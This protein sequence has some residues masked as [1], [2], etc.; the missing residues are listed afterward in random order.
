MELKVAQ[1]FKIDYEINRRFHLRER[2]GK[3]R[4]CGQFDTTP[5]FEDDGG[6]ICNQCWPKF[7]SEHVIK[8]TCEHCGTAVGWIK[9]NAE[10]K[11]CSHCHGLRYECARCGKEAFLVDSLNDRSTV[12]DSCKRKE[13]L[14]LFFRT[15]PP[16]YQETD[17]EQIPCRK[18][19]EAVL[20]MAQGPG[21][22]RNMF[23]WGESGLG[24]T[25]T[26]Y[27]LARKLIEN[28]N[29][30]LVLRGQE[31]GAEIYERTKPNGSCDVVGY[32]NRLARVQVLCIDEVDKIRYTGRTET[33]FFNLLERRLSNGKPTILIANSDAQYFAKR[34]AQEFKDPVLR[35]LKE[36]F[37][38]YKFQL[39]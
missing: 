24:K 10:P 13:T 12:C 2:E 31:F 9:G 14:A 37:T 30:V 7:E 26:L 39:V 36:F 18:T 22:S 6:P 32:I 5:F 25:R 27:L 15:V 4:L 33:E 19:A 28:G 3:C 29:T 1:P 38:P 17:P 8:S 11:L 23:L 16:L 20:K 21:F 35:R 34:F